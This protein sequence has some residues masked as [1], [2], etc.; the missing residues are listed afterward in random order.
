[1]RFRLT[2][3]HRK[4]ENSNLVVR[5]DMST[6]NTPLPGQLKEVETPKEMSDVY[7]KWRNETETNHVLLYVS[8]E[9]WFKS[10]DVTAVLRSFHGDNEELFSLFV[11][12][13]TFS[14]HT[15]DVASN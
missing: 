9:S 15:L 14:D 1:M 8:I 13:R 11:E 12:P 10:D 7:L 6:S 5:R 2:G 4:K 3:A